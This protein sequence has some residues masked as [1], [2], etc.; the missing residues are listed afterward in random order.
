MAG[1]DLGAFGQAAD[2]IEA[3]D[4]AD[5]L[6]FYGQTFH[7]AASVGAIPLMRFA[8]SARSGVG[9][10]DL[11]GLSAMYDM[12]RDC[13]A[14]GEFDRFEQVA[15]EHKAD[16][17]V[18]LEVCR[19]VYEALA[20]RPTEQPSPS[21]AGRRR[22]TSS[23]RRKSTR[24][25]G[26]GTPTDPTAGKQPAQVIDFGTPVTAIDPQALQGGTG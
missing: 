8:H 5:T 17:D 12:I 19:A 22:T 9:T 14:P 7:V 13:L 2:D 25:R 18:I 20:G 4:A 16:G 3:G 1:R 15:V 11:D 26:S 21:S 24:G 6:T 23:S 10:G